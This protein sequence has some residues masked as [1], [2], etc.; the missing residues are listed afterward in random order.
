MIYP[1]Y[2]WNDPELNFEEPLA[3][4]NTMYMDVLSQY[5][6]CG[7]KTIVDSLKEANVFFR[8]IS[9]ADDVSDET[10]RKEW[11][12][13]VYKILYPIASE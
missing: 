5:G 11:I 2:D 3:T 10:R 8:G 4:A 6:C 1:T 7:R 9:M 13:A 12:E